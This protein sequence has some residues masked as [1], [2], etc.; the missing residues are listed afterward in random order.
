MTRAKFFTQKE[1]GRS[2]ESNF[3]EGQ[4]PAQVKTATKTVSA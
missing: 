2:L 4:P 1:S 3:P